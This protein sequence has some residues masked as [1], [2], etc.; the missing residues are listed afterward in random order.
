MNRL[1][2][3]STSELIGE[4]RKRKEAQL[5]HGGLYANTE[6]RGK[7]GQENMKL[8]NDYW[9]LLISDFSPLNNS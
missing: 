2:K 9:I 4:L 8:P 5:F 3:Y 1:Q 7:Y 6:I